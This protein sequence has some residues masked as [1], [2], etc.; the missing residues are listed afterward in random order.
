[1]YGRE[2]LWSFHRQSLVAKPQQAMCCMVE[3]EMEFETEHFQQTAD[4]Q[5]DFIL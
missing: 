2:S 3:T 1:M 5:S 4:G